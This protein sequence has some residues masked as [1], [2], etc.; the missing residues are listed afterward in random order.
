MGVLG[1]RCGDE[2]G[3]S[4]GLGQL[5][6]SGAFKGDGFVVVGVAVFGI[7]LKAT[8]VEGDGLIGVPELCVL[9]SH[10]VEEEWV[11]GV[12]GEQFLK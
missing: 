8:V 1:P 2:T 3:L 9:L 5:H 7:D 12:G 6:A 10:S 11:A 4:R